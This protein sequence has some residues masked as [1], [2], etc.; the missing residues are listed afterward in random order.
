[1]PGVEAYASQMAIHTST[2]NTDISLAREYQKFF[3]TQHGH[4]ACWITVR[5]ESVPVNGGLMIMSFMYKKENMCHKYQLKFHL[6]QLSY[7]HCNFSVCMQ[8]LMG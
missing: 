4:M 6:Q 3:Q 1:M 2:A 7:Q 8:N 5:I